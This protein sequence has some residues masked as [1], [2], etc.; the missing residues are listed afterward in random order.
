M[1]MIYYWPDTMVKTSTKVIKTTYIKLLSFIFFIP[2][3][4]LTEA[5]TK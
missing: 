5:I 3:W 1:E 4:D 2:C